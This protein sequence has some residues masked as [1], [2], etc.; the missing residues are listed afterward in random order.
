MNVRSNLLREIKHQ[1]H[2]E[3][4]PLYGEHETV[5]MLNLLIQHFFNL[6]RVD[7]SLQP[8]FRLTETEMLKLHFAVKALKKEKPIQYIIGSTGFAGLTLKVTP[9]VLIPRPETEEMVEKIVAEIPQDDEVKILDVGTGSGCVALALKS[10]L[11]KSHLTGVDVSEAAI[12]V[13]SENIRL[14]HLDVSLL[15]LDI[16]NKESWKHLDKFDVIV[17][18]PPYVTMSDKKQMQNNVVNHEPHLALFVTDD[19]PLIFYRCI[20]ELAQSHLNEQ[21]RLWF[22]I[23]ESLGVEVTELLKNKGFHAVIL[24]HDLNNKPRFV[25][26]IKPK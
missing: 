25:S 18:N 4:L 23:N 24:H 20:A 17:S 26:C 8:D 14:N 3:L 7:Q 11:P 5:S 22:E 1:Y 6:S 21:G 16:L 10:K 2:R 13:A 15:Q 9:D 19:D 12:H